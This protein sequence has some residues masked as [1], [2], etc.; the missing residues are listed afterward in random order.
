M[1]LPP[2]NPRTPLPGIG[3]IDPTLSKPEL[4]DQME[5]LRHEYNRF[6]IET[7]N[8]M[9][10]FEKEME[11]IEKAYKLKNEIYNFNHPKYSYKLKDVPK[12]GSKSYKMVMRPKEL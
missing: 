10:Q 12:N 2:L 11:R 7:Y 6:K 5:F 1:N 4:Q 8:K 3:A 9:T